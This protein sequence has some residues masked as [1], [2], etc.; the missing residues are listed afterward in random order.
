M[1]VLLIQP[2]IQDFYLT[3]K[4]TVPYGL[5]CIAA[6]LKKAGFSV[7]I[8]DGLA[9]GKSRPIPIPS[10]MSYLETFY[11]RPDISP[12]CLFHG[13]RHFGY[14]FQHLELQIRNSGASIVGI[15]SLFTAY[16]MEAEKTAA[17][18][19]KALPDAVIVVGGHHPSAMPEDVMGW[20]SVDYAI[21]GEGE[22]ALPIL[23][24]T[25][26]HGG[27][28]SKVPGIVFKKTTGDLSISAPAVM[29]NLDTVAL[30]DRSVIK[31]TY[32]TRGRNPSTVLVTS[33]GCPLHCS[34]CSL[35]NR[36]L[37]PYRQRSVNS[38][39][40]EISE[41]AE[42][43]GARFIDFE[44]E[45]LSLN[46][47]W[48]MA[49][50]LE[51]RRKLREK[52]LELRA[53]NGLFPPSLDEEVI[54]AMKESGFKTLNLSLG[55]TCPRQLE[56]F[57]RPDVRPA[58]ENCLCLAEKYSLNAV[59]Y[60][61]CGAPGQDAMQSLEDLLY[62]AQRSVLAGL[63]VFYPSPGSIDFEA[64]KTLGILPGSHSLY[65]SSA[66][67][68]SHTTSRLQSITLLRISRIINFM[69]AVID[70]GLS[71]PPPAKLSAGS[72]SNELDRF[73]IGI[74]LLRGFLYDG[75]IRGVM[76]NG[77]I[78]PHFVDTDIV[79]RFSSILKSITV[80]G[81]NLPK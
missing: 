44:D 77:K 13:Y 61:I 11:G 50:L 45:N 80:A 23:V 75:C 79:R 66:I 22:T 64:S 32:Y 81:T 73:Q 26:K 3:A 56:R 76:Q 18:A 39:L 62:L 19:K 1:D 53:M 54:A 9:T 31:N 48:F 74:H 58:F 17:I 40:M 36:D 20:H 57:Q 27:D 52:N 14:S 69:K 16:S 38:V 25:I 33:R 65:R 43:Y 2:P 67:P 15:S 78:Y 49:L 35:G 10:E 21:R 63:S 68:V 29:E 51:I 47:K 46:K 5:A 59:G 30:P 70:R 60:V 34:Y 72:I 6:S 24:D 42:K 28:I 7:N 37:Y 4:R 41:A 8:L 71:I 12:F 55:S